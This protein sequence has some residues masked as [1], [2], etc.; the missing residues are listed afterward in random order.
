MSSG[1]LS[2][3][4]LVALCTSSLFAQTNTLLSG[5]VVDPTGAAVP[6][7]SLTLQNVNT[8]AERKT[9]SDG[10]GSYIFPQ[11][12]PGLYKLQAKAAGFADVVVNEIR[13]LVNTPATVNVAFE[14]IGTVAETVAVSAESIT[15]NTTDAS[16]GNSISG[17]V[18]TQLPFEA[19]NVV[20]LLSFQPGVSF[21][22]PDN[23]AGIT[24]ADRSG[25]VNGGRSDQAN[26]TLDGID[27]ND[28]QSRA[29][30]TSVLRVTLDSVQEFRMITTNAN[31]DQG[32][33]SGAQMA[34]V[35]K[36]GSNDIHGSLYHFLRNKATNA[37]SFTNNAAGVPLSKLNRNVFGASVGG[38]IRKDKLFYFLNFE[39]RRDRREDSIL[40][41][42]PSETLRNGTVRYIRSDNSI[43]D[44]PSAELGRRLDP[45]GIGA[46][47][48]ALAVLKLYPLPNSGEIGDGINS[49]GF[50]FNSPIQVKQ[51][52]YIAKIDYQATG[53]VSLFLR[54]NL[55]NDRDTDPLQFPGS[56]PRFVNLENSKGIAAGLNYNVNP[57][58]SSTTRYGFTR[59]GFEN[60][61]SSFT[62]QLS[63]RTLDDIYPITRSFRRIAPVHHFTQDFNWIKGS[64][65]FQ[66]GGNLRYL[67]N[68][69][70]NYANS[71]FGMSANASWMSGSGGIL[72]AP[73]TDM[74]PAFRV[75]FRD[76]T[77]AAMGIISQV[78]SRYNYLPQ[79][80]SVT[81]QT[82]GSP[83]LRKFKG[84]EYEM[85]IQD[86][87]KIRP[88]LTVTLGVRYAL[89]PPVYEANGVQTNSEMPLSDWFD[90][91]VGL[92]NA[93]RSAN[94]APLVRY[95]LSSQQGGR[96]L[97]PYNKNW[98]PRLA[99]AWAPAGRSG[100]GR[101]LFGAGQTSIR[102][103]I[104][105]Y[106]DILGMGLI[107]G[108]DATALGLSTSLNNPSGA[109]TLT[110]APRMTN[111]FTVPGPLV[112]PAPPAAFPV[113][114]PNNFAITNSLDD[115]LK[116]PYT[117]NYNLSVGREFSHGLFI[118]ASYVARLSRRT[119]TS[120]DLATPTN[121]KDPTSGMDYFTAA[122]QLTEQFRANVPTAQVRPIAFWENMF[123]GLAGA[124]LSATQRAYNVYRDNGPDSTAAL[125]TI[126]R[127]ADP[128]ASKFGRFAMFSPQYSYLRAIRSVGFGNYHSMQW[129]IRKRFTQGD[130]VEANY[131]WGKS[132]DLGSTAE[133]NQSATVRGVLINPYTR[134]QHRAV[135][136]YDTAHTF[137]M[138]GIYTL[139][140]GRG[141]ALAGDANSFANHI[142][143]G[144]QISG[145]WRHTSGFPTSVGN[146]R[147]WPTNYNVTG[148]ATQVAP[149]N[150]GT[151]KNA[152][153]PTAG[154]R[155]GANL[156]QDP[157]IALRAFVNTFP[158]EIG[159]R[160]TL[161]GDGVFNI[162]AGLGKRFSI[163]ENHSVQFRWEVFNLT[164]S[165]RFDPQQI[166]L[167]LG[168]ASAFG[169][170]TNTF[171]PPRIMQFALRYEF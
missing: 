127:F 105:I 48:A 57:R 42:V 154:G 126:D 67:S 124:G 139:P 26:V 106:H 93:G 32:R 41:T 1:V 45:L 77:M 120:E 99:V 138:G 119:L 161:R 117:I 91:R 33:S 137:S 25:A 68:D 160:N 6:S 22:P 168:N 11:V 75:S 108:F 145:L 166:T 111:L 142:I 13:L 112:S 9:V 80:G 110:T 147:F 86:S 72:N 163:K 85:Y 146:G 96:P 52:T 31:A 73:F 107:R 3:F 76:A 83:V 37:N 18:I 115:K 30:F 79:G 149:V 150:V 10:V 63:F 164:N 16:L 38:P 34:L 39:G 89:M 155:S 129:T 70:L 95:I 21:L 36:S 81:A 98:Q 125:E 140:I 58:L 88:A 123:P 162:D 28:Q 50:R 141:R 61:G 19:R 5:R 74:L 165:V 69:R 144:W 153:R 114:Q 171:S 46:N 82:P 158:G 101:K 44:L 53:N 65:N 2:S 113:T 49:G 121:L 157:S 109:L 118:Q 122:R 7:A 136:D 66:F 40:R 92:A 156:F 143:G 43:A 29:A 128:S 17:K 100:I 152:P 102:A 12:V 60:S 159:G 170:Y 169:R 130:Q 47:P 62:T 56:A 131:A 78:T 151:N 94:E 84:E 54:G 133:N 15:L 35:T 20:G 104:G 71:F 90:M 8:G 132:M 148:Y 116:A 55:Q 134:R 87:W 97:Y 103:G 135:S 64:H 167:D 24:L 51:N 59:Q 4:L 23:Q 27:V 14:K